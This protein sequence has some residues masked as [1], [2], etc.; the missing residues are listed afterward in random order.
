MHARS[1]LGNIVFPT[2]VLDACGLRIIGTTT[3]D[4][5]QRHLSLRRKS[6]RET[7]AKS[8]VSYLLRYQADM[9]VCDRVADKKDLAKQWAEALAAG[10]EKQQ[11]LGGYR[12]EDV[13]A[14]N[15]FTKALAAR[16]RLA[17]AS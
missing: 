7:V 10:A 9:R 11:P 17:V 5:S 12:G 2:T 1:L 14:K 4:P 13:A 16:G 3:H 8:E 15:P 6:G